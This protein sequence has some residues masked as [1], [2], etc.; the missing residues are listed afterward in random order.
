MNSEFDESIKL[1]IPIKKCLLLKFK[2]P[3]IIN[4]IGNNNNNNNK[5]TNPEQKLE[6]KNYLN[7]KRVIQMLDLFN[8]KY[9][10]KKCRKKLRY[11]A[12]QIIHT[13][14]KHNNNI[15]TNHSNKNTRQIICPECHIHFKVG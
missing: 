6:L 4:F 3:S 12:D 13:K 14:L 7:R 2:K 5:K 15:Q 10:C 11:K 8:S 1:N 9:D